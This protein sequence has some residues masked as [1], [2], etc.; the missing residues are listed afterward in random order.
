[1]FAMQTHSECESGSGLASLT[2]EGGERGEAGKG[3][4]LLVVHCRLVT[5]FQPDVH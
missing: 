1:M 2:A 5:R 3:G 4:L